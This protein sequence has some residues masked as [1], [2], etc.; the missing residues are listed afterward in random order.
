MIK[1]SLKKLSLVFFRIIVCIL[2]GTLLMTLVYLIPTKPIDNNVRK[3]AHIFKKEGKRPVLINGVTSQCD[4]YTDA[5]ILLEAANKNDKKILR[6]AME[7][8]EGNI[9]KLTPTEVLVNHYI[10]N[11][12]FT[13]QHIYPRYWHGNL[14]VVKPLMSFV[15]YYGF[16]I[17]NSIIVLLTMVLVIWFLFKKNEKEFIAPYI[18]SML[19]LMPL[20][21]AFSIQLSS[22]F[23]VLNF[24][25]IALLATKNK[26]SD[27]SRYIF[28]Y[29]GIATAFFDLLTYPIATFGVPCALY[30]FMCGRK[31]LKYY[32]T[33][34]LK[35]GIL[36]GVGYAVMWF[37]KWL[38]AT[39]ITD[40]NVF[41]DAFV[42]VN[43]RTYAGVT[44]TNKFTSIIETEKTN[45]KY[46]LKTP[47]VFIALIYILI[48]I[49]LII[50]QHKRIKDNII[51][52]VPF[53]VL[54]LVPCV[55]YAI[56]AQHSSEHAWFT[57]KA[58]VVL[59]ISGLSIPAFLYKYNKKK[60]ER[61]AI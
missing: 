53:V 36:W 10:N 3:S 39:C 40:R 20:T 18:I 17:I 46:F 57:Y 26:A 42:K 55:W 61:S 1:Q 28:L 27:K 50:K 22:C 49:V 37:A 12:P 23:Y 48:M 2:I 60:E 25:M 13:H 8:K 7:V 43:T 56:A 32:F 44:A 54:M 14:L 33:K 51:L 6:S 58:L 29:I 35:A 38:I 15:S 4:N 41:E 31:P 16:R 30:L 47:A 19:F 59:A 52:V 5:L 45:I 34:M 11:V 21:I 24:G 9:G